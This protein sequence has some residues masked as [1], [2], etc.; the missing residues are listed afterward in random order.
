VTQD[1]V[2]VWEPN[3][4]ASLIP[5]DGAKVAIGRA[6]SN[7]ITLDDGEISRLHAAL[8]RYPSGWSIR[9]LNSANGTLVN[10]QRIMAEH[11]LAAGDEIRVG[12]V[13][14]V[15]RSGAH[16]SLEATISAE[17][18]PP[19]LTGRERDVL[20]ALCRPLMTSQAFAQAATIQEM[21]AELVV[22][23][24]TIKFNLGNLYDKFGILETG[25]TRR[26]QLANEAVRRG[27]V[28][29][30]ELQAKRPSS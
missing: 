1:Y 25:H 12:S 18:K 3:T 8:E 20:V 22:N 19:K 13:R 2:E 28:T 9:D 10:G 27:A 21:A 16:D 23:S 6:T 11:R 4:P 5:L 14:L 7:D 29:M 24:G 30:A 26:G 17:Q 15:F